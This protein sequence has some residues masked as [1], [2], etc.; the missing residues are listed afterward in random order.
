MALATIAVSLGLMWSASDGL[1]IGWVPSKGPGSG[2]WPFWL[3]FGMLISSIITLVRWFVRATPESR[4][5]EL[6]LSR[7]AIV[8]VGIAVA[9]LLFLLIGIHLIG[10]YLALPIFLFFYIKI[11]GKHGW[12]ITVML[13]GGVP[14]FIFALFE[15]GLQIPLP[16]AV[17]EEWFYPVFDVMYGSDIFWMYVAGSFAF[18]AAISYALHKLLQPGEG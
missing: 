17:T 10:I 13:V 4:S 12:S 7:D 6:Y 3:A 1:A 14:V 2:F 16:K 18:L 11:V 5:N 15:W 8:V 9:A